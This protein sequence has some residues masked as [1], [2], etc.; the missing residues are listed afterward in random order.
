[1]IL[2]EAKTADI[3]VQMFAQLFSRQVAN[4]RLVSAQS[5]ADIPSQY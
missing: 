5:T 3:K 1:M 4:V 2:L